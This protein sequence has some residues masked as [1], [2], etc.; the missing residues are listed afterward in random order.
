MFESIVNLFNTF[1]YQPLFNLLLL[2]YIYVPGKDFGIAIICLTLVIKI[3]LWP[4]SVKAVK[5]Q[6]ALQKIQPQIA[7]LQKKYKDDK[8]KQ[9]REMLEI[10]KKEKINPF[11]GLFLALIQLPILIALYYVFWNGLKPESLLLL[12]NFIPSPGHINSVFLGIIDLA[13]PN[14]V[15]ALIAGFVQYY[16]TKMLLP[17]M[18]KAPLSSGQPDFSQMM[19]T[20]MTYVFPVL[21]VIVLI[22]LPSALGLYWAVSSIISVIQQHFAFKEKK[23]LI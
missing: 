2:F 1:L 12:Y 10:Y 17:K 7:E 14:M 21:T 16:Q 9:A 8:E 11:S 23:Q 18:K 20:Q 15:I 3:V 4:T 13:K 19:Q 6:K 5:S 22:G